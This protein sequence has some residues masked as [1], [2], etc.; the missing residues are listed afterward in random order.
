MRPRNVWILSVSQA[1]A[2]A[3]PPL[4]LLTGGIVGAEL[5]P[6]PTWST[7]PIAI[8]VVGVAIFTIPAAFFMKNFGRRRG[9]MGA[10]IMAGLG[11][12]LAAYAIWI[13]SFVL[14][15]A[16]TVL[17]GGNSA[18]VQQFRFAAA[19]SVRPEST[20]KAV[21]FVLIGGAAAGYLGPEL[22]KLAQNWLPYGVYTGSYVAIA[23]LYAIAFILLSF[24]RNVKSTGEE[25]MGEERPIVEVVIQPQ[26]IVALLAGIVAYGVMSF[27]MTATPI[28]M[29]VMD[30][31]SIDQ[32]AFVIESHIMA[33]YLPS[34][35]TG[36][37][38]SRWGAIK[39]AS[40]GAMSML[41]CA[42]LGIASRSLVNYWVALVLLGIGWNF[43]FV[44]GT[45]LLTQTYLTA[46]RFKAQAVND[47]SVFGIQAFS[48]LSA[49]AVIFRANWRV[50]NLINLPVLV[51]MM[52]AL[53]WL[54]RR[55]AQVTSYSPS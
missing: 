20:G 32:T 40:T 48:S 4:V 7:L 16:A 36:L 54:T 19:E 35:I 39:I 52:L 12:L 6:D 41:A 10:V 9:F 51:I 2:N 43:L 55:A 11:A 14:L 49:G 5:A 33:M 27:I 44:G 22:G 31:F 26:Y 50:L 34:L 18:F 17:I 13:R 47:F 37:L 21:S 42:L 38:I 15:C 46:E 25:V 29:H 28:S 23:V 30:G 8:M 1:F 45:V 24:Y 53:L 3:G